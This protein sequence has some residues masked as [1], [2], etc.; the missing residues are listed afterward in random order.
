MPRGQ[1]GEMVC[2]LCSRPLW[3]VPPP[4]NA[5]VQGEAARINQSVTTANQR[6]AGLDAVARARAHM[7]AKAQEIIRC[8]AKGYAEKQTWR[9]MRVTDRTWHRWKRA[10]KAVGR[11]P[12]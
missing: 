9:M 8:A 5:L 6:Q 1:D 2:L 4:E 7:E 10:L 11:W 3:R 12:W